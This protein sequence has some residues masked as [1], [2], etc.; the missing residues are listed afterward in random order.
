MYL[1]PFSIAA[2]AALTGAAGLIV[3]WALARAALRAEAA[4]EYEERLRSRPGTVAGVER[5]AFIRLYA[6]AFEPRW[7]LYA[8]AALAGAVAVTPLALSGL[9]IV[10]DALWRLNGA[11]P[12]FA[13]GYYPW[14]FYM[15]FAVVGVWALCGWLAARIHHLRAPEPFQAALARAR[16]EPFD[17]VEIPRPRP[18]WARRIRR[19]EAGPAEEG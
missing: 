5:T 11:P 12:L 4:A 14:M 10:W 8:A 6:A 17:A 13:A 1:D 2:I 3:R 7:A 18:K 15:F 9:V 16:G 19:P